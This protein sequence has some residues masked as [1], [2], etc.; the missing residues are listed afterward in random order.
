MKVLFVY[1]VAGDVSTRA[2]ILPNWL[3][4]HTGMSYVA[5]AL[6]QAGHQCAL[7][8]VSERGWRRLLRRRITEYG[9]GMVCFTAVASQYPFV[10]QVA[11]YVK[12]IAPQMFLLAGG[13]H[14]SLNPESCVGE[15]FDAVCV[16][17]GELPT[18]ELAGLLDAGDDPRG[19]P[20]LW[21]AQDGEV[22][23]NPT[24]GWVADLDAF[25]FPDREMWREWVDPSGDNFAMVLLG[26]GCPFSCTYCCN[27]ALRRLAKGA[28]VR[29]RSPEKIVEELE[30][31]ADYL[32]ALQTAY[33]EVETIAVRPD[34]A[35]DLCDQLRAFKSR[36][37]RGI[38][39]GANVRIT[40]SL[41]PD[42]LFEAMRKAGFTFVNAGIESGSER[43]RKE[44]LRRNYSNED[45]LRVFESAKRH[46]LEVNSY[47][48]IGFPG[49]TP[50][51]FEETIELTRRCQP[52]SVDFTI[53]YP[54]PGTDLYEVCRKRGVLRC[55]AA[56]YRERVEP[57]L[58]LPEF[59]RRQIM[60][61]YRWFQWDVYKDKVPL[62]QALSRL[63]K[64]NLQRS[65]LARRGVAL[66][67]RLGLWKGQRG[68]R[69][70]L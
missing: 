10:Q 47:V 20:S 26:R 48:M 16:G 14:V 23:R 3:S 42:P 63:V 51:D 54:Y 61:H 40:P 18:V 13:T 21:V 46:G 57:V 9:P 5:A 6:K 17:E 36:T 15:P 58:D 24:R 49:E 45:V 53:F 60:R 27:H 44:V 56:G 50:A 64:F 4:I 35:I 25:G 2:R 8:V 66:L 69:R 59:S 65:A 41:D 7:A 12:K 38:S 22:T 62:R 32:P 28:Y 19:V 37:G 68:E 52:G 67:H 29:Y 11:R 1:T 70:S 43:V 33:L 55:E 30:W 31:L 39:F 34:W